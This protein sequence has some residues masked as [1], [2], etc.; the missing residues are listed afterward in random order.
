MGGKRLRKTIEIKNR[1]IKS[2]CI[3]FDLPKM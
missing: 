3:K 2:I 1:P